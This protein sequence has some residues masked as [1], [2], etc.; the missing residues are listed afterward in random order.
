M[1]ELTNW[2][3]FILMMIFL[4]MQSCKKKEDQI[5]ALEY[6]TVTDIDGNTYKTVKIGDQWWMAENLKVTRFR[7]GTQLDSVGYYSVDSLWSLLEVPAFTSTNDSLYGKL[8][9][10]KAVS[11]LKKIAPTGWHIPSDEEWKKMELEIGMSEAE[12]T[13]TGWRGTSE[14]EKLMPVASSGWPTFSTPFG[15]NE[16]GFNALPG[17]CKL[18][19]GG[20]CDQ[21]NM[22]FWWTSSS[23]NQQEAWYRYLDYHKKTIY[24]QHT[25]MNYGFSIRCIKD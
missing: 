25:Y 19:N 1:K 11:N 12:V 4:T 10:W 14:A 16:F 7:D 5:K 22:A 6:G 13:K 23:E 2:K 15:T 21:S 9:N 20:K 18:F 3:L 24:R 17:G 8:Y